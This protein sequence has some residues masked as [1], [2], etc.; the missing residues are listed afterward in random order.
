MAGVGSTLMA[1]KFDGAENARHDHPLFADGANC[2]HMACFRRLELMA[3]AADRPA[4]T[5][6]ESVHA[7]VV[8]RTLL[9]P[10]QRRTVRHRERKL[11][12]GTFEGIG[13]FHRRDELIDV[14]IVKGDGPLL[15]EREDVHEAS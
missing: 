6:A 11:S 5:I 10:F 15:C 7:Y 13:A 14:G 2:L 4:A 1:W 12:A 3:L 9:F 8:F